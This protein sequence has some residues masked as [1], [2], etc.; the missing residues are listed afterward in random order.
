ML[1]QILAEFHQ[2]AGPLCLDDLSRKLDV[3]TSALDGM[4]QTLVRAGRLLELAP[5]TSGCAACPAQ[6]GCL[7]LT[8]GPQ[9]RYFLPGESAN[10]R[11]ANKA[12]P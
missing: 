4:L 3:E 10:K 12:L 8:Y 1:R 2:A 5:T 7:I 11:M 6:G 9:K